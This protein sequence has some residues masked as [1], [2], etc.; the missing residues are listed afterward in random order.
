MILATNTT[1][2]EMRSTKAVVAVALLLGSF[3]SN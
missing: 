1:L 2:C 3:V